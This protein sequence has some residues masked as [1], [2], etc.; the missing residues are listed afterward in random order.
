MFFLAMNQRVWLVTWDPGAMACSAQFNHF[1][2]FFLLLLLFHHCSMMGPWGPVRSSDLGLWQRTLESRVKPSSESHIYSLIY[3]MF[4]GVTYLNFLKPSDVDKTS[5]IIPCIN[6]L[7]YSF[8]PQR[9]LNSLYLNILYSCFHEKH[10]TLL[11]LSENGLMLAPVI[12]SNSEEG[13][14]CVT[15]IYVHYFNFTFVYVWRS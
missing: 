11:S 7:S 15:W 5:I 3:L 1:L 14:I 13:L 12:R 4:L 6:C 2:V 10:K 8:F 9:I